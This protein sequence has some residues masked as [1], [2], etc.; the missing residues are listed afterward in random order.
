M[1]NASLSQLS[2]SSLFHTYS[3]TTNTPV[4]SIRPSKF[5]L[6]FSPPKIFMKYE[7]LVN[8]LVYSRKLHEM[9]LPWLTP[10]HDTSYVCS[11]LFEQHKKYL[12]PT[13][14]SLAQ[15]L[16]I[17]FDVGHACMVVFSDLTCLSLLGFLFVRCRNLSNS[18]KWNF[19]PHMWP[20]ESL[21]SQ[22]M[23]TAT[24]WLTTTLSMALQTPTLLTLSP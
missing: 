11:L 24:W 18:W 5:Y 10:Q 6:K 17:H 13:S 23:S 2:R 9:A 14:V 16:L 19:H 21:S 12:T 22:T 1:S 20:H 7:I 15:V 3:H 4:V 8:D